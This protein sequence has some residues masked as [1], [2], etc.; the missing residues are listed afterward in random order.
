MS[1]WVG[2]DG[3]GIGCGVRGIFGVTGV[4]EFLALFA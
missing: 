1:R 4:R 3:M 2:S